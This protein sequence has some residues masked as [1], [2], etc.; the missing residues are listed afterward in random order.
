[1][2]RSKVILPVLQNEITAISDPRMESVDNHA[3]D[4]RSSRQVTSARGHGS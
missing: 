1:M 3:V 2:F 4:A